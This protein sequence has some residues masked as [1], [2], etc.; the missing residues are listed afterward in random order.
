MKP[1]IFYTQIVLLGL[2]NFSLKAQ[3]FQWAYDLSTTNCQKVKHNP[4]D[5]SLFV[6]GSV[7][8][9][10]NFNINNKGKD[11]FLNKG[12]LPSSGN[13]ACF[14]KYDSLGSLQFAV[15]TGTGGRTQNHHVKDI[16]IDPRNNFIFVLYSFGGDYG[17]S[18]QLD[19]MNPNNSATLIKVGIQRPDSP[20]ES[21]IVMYKKTG[22]YF[23]HFKLT[24]IGPYIYDLA[25]DNSGDLYLTGSFEGTTNI[26]Y[27]SQ[28]P[29]N[30]TS[31]GGRD[32]YIAKY[33]WNMSR[34]L[35]CTTFGG[36]ADDYPSCIEA[37]NDGGV[38]IGGKFKSS[39]L[40]SPSGNG[41]TFRLNNLSAS[42]NTSDAFIA[43]WTGSGAISYL[44]GFGATGNDFIN[45]LAVDENN[46]C[47]AAGVISGTGADFNISNTGLQTMQIEGDDGALVAF[48]PNGILLWYNKV[49]GSGSDNAQ[50]IIYNGNT[51]FVS[52][53]YEQGSFVAPGLLNSIK[54]SYL[55]A[56]GYI[57]EYD[58]T[59]GNCKNA[60]TIGGNYIEESL[61]ITPFGSN[62]YFFALASL[63][64]HANKQ[65]SVD[66]DG[67]PLTQSILK[68][69]LYNNSYSKNYLPVLAL[70][71]Y[72]TSNKMYLNTGIPSNQQAFSA[73]VTGSIYSPNFMTKVYFEYGTDTTLKLN[74][75]LVTEKLME[76][77]STNVKTNLNNLVIN[78]IYFY[79]IVME[80]GTGIYRGKFKSFTTKVSTPEILKVITNIDNRSAKL[81]ATINPNGTTTTVKL[82]YG[83]T[84]ELQNAI[85]L[86]LP[87]LT[88][89][90][91]TITTLLV[92]LLPSK[93][94]YYKYELANNQ[95][96]RTY[97]DSFVVK[98]LPP[99]IT[100]INYIY[101]REISINASYNP[102]GQDKDNKVELQYGRTNLFE[103]NLKLPLA[104]DTGFSYLP[105]NKIIIKKLN[106]NTSY[107]FR[108][109]VSN[110]LGT[111]YS[112]DTTISTLA[113]IVFDNMRFDN[114]GT[115]KI[116]ASTS[117]TPN[118]L[119]TTYRMLVKDKS[120]NK[121]QDV[122][123]KPQIYQY[124]INFSTF[125][126]KLKGNNNY[127]IQFKAINPSGTYYSKNYSFKTLN[128][129]FI[130]RDQ[131]LFAKQLTYLSSSSTK[132]KS[133]ITT[134]NGIFFAGEATIDGDPNPQ[135][136]PYPTRNISG[137]DGF[138][139]NDVAGKGDYKIYDGR[140]ELRYFPNDGI[141]GAYEIKNYS[142]NQNRLRLAGLQLDYKKMRVEKDGLSLDANL[143]LPSIISNRF[144]R[145]NI[146]TRLWGYSVRK[147]G[148]DVSGD[149]TLT[150]VRIL[151]ILDVKRISF[152]FDTKKDWYSGLGD[153]K[154]PLFDATIY[155]EI[156]RGKLNA[157]NFSVS[158]VYPILIGNTGIAITRFGGGLGG[159]VTKPVSIN[160]NGDLGFA[161]DKTFSSVKL[162]NLFA[163]YNVGTS[164]EGGGELAV[165]DINLARGGFMFTNS[166]FNCSGYANLLG[167]V[168]CDAHL[169][170]SYGDR[171]YMSGSSVAE[172]SIPDLG[173]GFPADLIDE[174]IPDPLF[175]QTVN[176]SNNEVSSSYN[177][178]L[179]VVSAGITYG[180]KFNGFPSPF[181]RPNFS[182]HFPR[183]WPFRVDSTV[184]PNHPNPFEGRSL[185]I[186]DAVT[187]FK[188]E[189][190]SRLMIIRVKTQGNIPDYDLMCPNGQ[191]ITKENL[192]GLRA[193]HKI[194]SKE[195]KTFY[196]IENP[197]LGNYKII[198]RKQGNAS[199]QF[200][201]YLEP[202]FASVKINKVEITNNLAIIETS[203]TTGDNPAK[204]TLFYDRDTTFADGI[205]IGQGKIL[206]KKDTIQW[207]LNKVPQGE[208][209]VYAFVQD[210]FGIRKVMFKTPI[211]IIH[212]NHPSTPFDPSFVPVDSGIKCNWRYKGYQPIDF[213]IEI[214]ETPTFTTYKSYS[215]GSD[216]SF[217]FKEL[218]PGGQYFM[219]IVAIDT[220]YKTSLPSKIVKVNYVSPNL[221]NAP[222]FTTAPVIPA[223]VGQSYY[224]KFECKDYDNNA[225][226]YS[227]KQ[228][229]T[230]L[231]IDSL[232][233]LQGVP[234]SSGLAYVE[235][236]ASDGTLTT[237]QKFYIQVSSAYK[238]SIEQGNPSTSLPMIIVPNPAKEYI[239]L[240]LQNNFSGWFDLTI[241]DLIG[242]K[243]AMDKVE[244]VE[245]KT[246]KV[247]SV[248]TLKHGAYIIELSQGSLNKKAKLI[249][250]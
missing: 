67:S 41:K 223:R 229:P 81:I 133:D 62:G 178:N 177:I 32:V 204:Y 191:I 57:L 213:M 219:R 58:K 113:D 180:L 248:N 182:L 131:K 153:L 240:D 228:G 152:S 10:T 118:N 192:Q 179:A 120:T 193:F 125:L 154:T 101:P 232:S 76:S 188:L 71:K 220:L 138:G 7:F 161:W 29:Y 123:I 198:L 212:P 144:T 108:L 26:G 43:K 50:S 5:G 104:I 17:A 117:A 139:V 127:Q 33:P 90:I 4:V 146:S 126:N 66:V 226:T 234:D 231:K 186:T 73:T 103:T 111:I 107:H 230:W 39:I 128:S 199:Y 124:S 51:L 12:D 245:G 136:I 14:A 30:I 241:S 15:T 166:A 9:K 160:V 114:I 25:F 77:D 217:L 110:E 54:N 225:L 98:L 86:S 1:V 8:Y 189:K 202:I 200:D 44:T 49:G 84:K 227:I 239:Q 185:E 92:N 151:N 45:K 181:V 34:V 175:S 106:T 105:V 56:N 31:K 88:G 235:L 150:D 112:K 24:Q 207:N 100:S 130:N 63:Y 102:N 222:F 148:I 196:G 22:E 195:S 59:N 221:N 20:S 122:A 155:G 18:V 174:A 250:Q 78:K 74:R 238:L 214:S 249:K 121:I 80:N 157:I 6:Y 87:T 95:G 162:N 209:F 91:E 201:I 141:L 2:L 224:Y 172:V 237:L 42:A 35:S 46:N 38:Y 36:S 52:G 93:K 72:S 119:P 79:R 16:E 147:T 82:Y 132:V 115:F 47:Y 149:I 19:N 53:I 206:S 233:T 116:N 184:A 55:N 203:G 109:K 69:I 156:L 163:T 64:N 170:I 97:L 159:L 143:V 28:L 197:E 11:Y 187:E 158:P 37:A 3:S 13:M 21:V 61:E 183:I 99:L 247:L 68:S 218:V 210:T 243:L 70:G 60:K 75:K 164:L 208:Y 244:L 134:S 176:F 85:S 40:T 211:T 242:K 140:V 89:D 236:E 135:E 205:I 169:G 129:I 173:S 216:S 165:F 171:F 137:T 65:D 23:A 48:D 27:L 246:V 194:N 142:R 145:D 94:Y 168:K 215:V 96:S 167:I 190:A 83:L